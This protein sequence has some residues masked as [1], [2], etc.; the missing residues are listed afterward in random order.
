MKKKLH[1]FQ[2]N[3]EHSGIQLITRVIYEFNIECVW[4]SNVIVPFKFIGTNTN[5]KLVEKLI[6]F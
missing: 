3:N 4:L 5:I 2:N 1:L 6:I